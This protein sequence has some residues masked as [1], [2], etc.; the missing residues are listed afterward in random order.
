[1]K[2]EFRK[3]SHH[4]VGLRSL[5]P[6]RC[7]A[8]RGAVFVVIPRGWGVGGGGGGVNQWWDSREHPPVE[9]L[10]AAQSCSHPPAD[11]QS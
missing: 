4:S 6:P 11:H 7:P 1:M 9:L 2:E 3:W 10:T 8:G 5:R